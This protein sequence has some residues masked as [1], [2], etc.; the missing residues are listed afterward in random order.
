MADDKM[1]AALKKICT[2]NGF[3]IGIAWKVSGDT[4]VSAGTPFFVADDKL[5]AFKTK[6]ETFK[7]ASGKGLPGRVWA[8]GKFEFKDDVQTFTA[9]QYPR[10]GI[11]TECG[12]HG[13]YGF[14]VMS[15]SSVAYMAEFFTKEKATQ[16]EA[17]V[18]SI[19]STLAT[20]C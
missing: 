20:V 6:S 8:S 18:K 5:L 12:V 7:F 13:C 16:N 15:G 3:A 11:A 1:T 10:L 4:L 17:L 9:E 2:E 19:A 14:P